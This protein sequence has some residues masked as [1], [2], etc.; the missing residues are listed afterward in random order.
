MFASFSKGQIQKEL[1]Q[2]D[3]LILIINLY[4]CLICRS[5]GGLPKRVTRDFCESSVPA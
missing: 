1:L 5:D 3:V 4:F 2:E